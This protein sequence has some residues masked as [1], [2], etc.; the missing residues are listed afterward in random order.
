MTCRLSVIL[1][2]TLFFERHVVS[3]DFVVSAAD[4]IFADFVVFGRLCH[5]AVI[6]GNKCRFLHNFANYIVLLQN[7]ITLILIYCLDENK[8][9][10][11][12]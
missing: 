4:V 2:L 9:N 3:A 12:N 5:F 11:K 6:F 7:F 10:K 1:K 8:Y